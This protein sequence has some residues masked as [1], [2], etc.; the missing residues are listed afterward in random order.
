MVVDLQ[1]LAC[2]GRI[3]HRRQVGRRIDVEADHLPGSQRGVELGQGPTQ[4]TVVRARYRQQEPGGGRHGEALGGG[5]PARP[6]YSAGK[7]ARTECSDTS[8][9]MSVSGV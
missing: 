1:G 5:Q 6:R 3:A 8:I 7:K 9:S 4:R 2:L